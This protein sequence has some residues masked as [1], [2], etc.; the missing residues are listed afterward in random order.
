MFVFVFAFV[1]VSVSILS[2]GTVVSCAVVVSS[3]PD[4]RLHVMSIQLP[5]SDFDR[6]WKCLGIARED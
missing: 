1:F 5:L 2:L 6:R 4:D 3:D